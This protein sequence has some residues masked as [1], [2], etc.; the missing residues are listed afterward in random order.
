M[1]EEQTSPQ[2]PGPPQPRPS[3]KLNWLVKWVVPLVVSIA[4]SASGWSAFGIQRGADTQ[5]A[6]LQ[7]ELDQGF[8]LIDKRMTSDEELIT[9]AT[10]KGVDLEK[11]Q[12][13]LE[14]QYQLILN[15]LQDI[16]RRLN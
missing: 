15:I 3:A 9:N 1:D 4:I 11:R 13:T 2:Q 8:A 12:S 14:G 10:L 6:V 16:Q 5:H 7:R